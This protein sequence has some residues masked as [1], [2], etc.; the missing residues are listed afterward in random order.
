[1][2]LQHRKSHGKLGFAE[3]ARVTAAAWK[4]LDKDA[5]APFEERA[6]IEKEEYKQALKIWTAKTKKSSPIS[7]DTSAAPSA[8]RAY[9]P[10]PLKPP[11]SIVADGQF[12]SEGLRDDFHY[13]KPP[14]AP[15]NLTPASEPMFQEG[16]SHQSSIHSISSLGS[17]AGSTHQEIL[18]SLYSQLPLVA[19][20]ETTVPP[21]GMQSPERDFR[22]NAAFDAGYQSAGPGFRRQS[23]THFPP[24]N[25]DL[26]TSYR[27]QSTPDYSTTPISTQVV[28]THSSGRRSFSVSHAVTRQQGETMQGRALPGTYSTGSDRNTLGRTN[29]DQHFVPPRASIHRPE[30][31]TFPIARLPPQHLPT[32]ST[33]QGVT[34]RPETDVSSETALQEAIATAAEGPET[35]E[36]E[37]EM[38]RLLKSYEC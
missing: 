36:E 24:R 6:A 21:I 30:S 28:Q 22:T 14:E 4:A 15:R 38:N 33:Q 5:K 34:Y 25:A 10:I 17:Q 37:E 32:R 29:W 20:R 3:L 18:A 7:K 2:F 12:V 31:Q 9:S 8:E 19:S 1:M 35:P 23:A 16:S 27:R 26:E 13:A 11:K